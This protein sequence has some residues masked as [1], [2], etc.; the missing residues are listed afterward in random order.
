MIK[1]AF[2]IYAVLSGGSIARLC[3]VASVM[4]GKT[5]MVVRL[6]PSRSDCLSLPPVFIRGPKQESAF[7]RLFHLL[8]KEGE[9]MLNVNQIELP[10]WERLGG[11]VFRG[12][13]YH[14]YRRSA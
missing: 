9:V 14:V 12:K 11:V 5:E 10:E 7:F 4:P 1:E 3:A 8:A 13:Y 2:L 6:L